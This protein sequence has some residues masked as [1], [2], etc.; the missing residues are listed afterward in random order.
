MF[1]FQIKFMR[2][3][4]PVLVALKSDIVASQTGKNFLFGVVAQTDNCFMKTPEQTEHVWGCLG[5][6]VAEDRTCNPHFLM[7]NMFFPNRKSLPVD[8]VNFG[9]HVW[10]SSNEST[11][12]LPFQ[13]DLVL[14]PL[15]MLVSCGKN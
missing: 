8:E 6:A 5:Y 11:F 7:L 10:K 4:L 3:Q 12:R 14:S 13:E 9:L 15:K 1:N 2:I